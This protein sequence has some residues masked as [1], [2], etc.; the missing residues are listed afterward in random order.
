[1]PEFKTTEVVNKH[2]NVPYDVYIGRG[3][4][5]GN[6]FTHRDGTKAVFKVDSREE[7]ISAYRK[8]VLQQ[9]AL[10]ADLHELQ[11]KTLCCFCKPAG[12]HGDVLSELANHKTAYEWLERTSEPDTQSIFANELDN[13]ILLYREALH[14]LS[15]IAPT[16]TISDFLT[17]LKEH[18]GNKLY[19][20]WFESKGMPMLRGLVE[21]RFVGTASQV[22]K[23][24]FVKQTLGDDLNWVQRDVKS[25]RSVIVNTLTGL[26]SE[27]W[28]LEQK[29]EKRC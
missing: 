7:A 24:Q 25:T 4:K 10:L 5:W 23:I 21:T 22:A 28:Q 18:E 11:G 9:P 27:L 20:G 8:W 1:M 17:Q 14:Q 13:L 6:P 29:G 15:A 16:A 26:A 3:S 12:C 2:H 19:V